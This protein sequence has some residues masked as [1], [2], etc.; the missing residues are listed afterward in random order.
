ML[1]KLILPAVVAALMVLTMPSQVE[2][3]GAAHAG[4]TH[5]GPGGAYHTSATAVAGPRGVDMTGHTTAV[6]YGGGVYHS[7]Y[8]AAAGYGGAGYHYGYG[9][10]GASYG[11]NSHGANY[12]ANAAAAAANG[13]YR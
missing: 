3:Y 13:A 6:G 8:G 2:A 5:V 7:G 10:V 1:N 11:Y 9:G 12:N 4:Y